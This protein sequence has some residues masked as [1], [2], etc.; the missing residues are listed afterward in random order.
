MCIR[1]RYKNGGWVFWLMIPEFLESSKETMGFRS[2]STW[3]L[4][5]DF[6]AN[7]YPKILVLDHLRNNGASRWHDG[8]Q[9]L[10]SAESDLKIEMCIRDSL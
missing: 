3:E 1:D 8:Q 10:T 6:G 5:S 2:N 9:F 7:Q 4:K